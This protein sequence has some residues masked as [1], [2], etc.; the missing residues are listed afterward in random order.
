MHRLERSVKTLLGGWDG[1][2]GLNRFYLATIIALSSAAACTRH[3]FSPREGVL[4]SK[5]NSRG[6]KEAQAIEV[7]LYLTN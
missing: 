5:M 2:G 1:G 4:M 6:L 3:L 7:R